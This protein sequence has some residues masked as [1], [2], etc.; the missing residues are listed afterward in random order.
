MSDIRLPPCSMSYNV[1]VND[2]SALKY[3]YHEVG[4]DDV[5]KI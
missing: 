4:I 1:Q 3:L 2:V 5:S